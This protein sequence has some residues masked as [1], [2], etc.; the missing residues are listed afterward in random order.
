[1]EFPPPSGPHKGAE[2]RG[3]APEAVRYLSEE[4]LRQEFENRG[5]SSRGRIPDLRDR[6]AKIVKGERGPARYQG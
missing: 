2:N 6:L 3:V 5:L 1:M 4:E